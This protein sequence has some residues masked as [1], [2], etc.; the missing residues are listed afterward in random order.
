MADL[1]SPEMAQFLTDARK[2]INENQAILTLIILPI[3]GGIGK[4]LYDRQR[5]RPTVYLELADVTPIEGNEDVTFCLKAINTGGDPATK[6]RYTWTQRS[7]LT[8]TPVPAGFL[9]QKDNPRCFSFSMKADDVIGAG[10]VGWHQHPLGWIELTYCAGWGL[11]RQAKTA[12][13]LG[14]SP[15]MPVRLGKVPSPP[16]RDYIIP[17][18]NWH[19][20]RLRDK[21]IQN[22]ARYL[23]HSRE[24]L[25]ARGI[26]VQLLF[27]DESFRRLLGELQRRG[28]QWSY[29]PGGRGYEVYAKKEGPFYSTIRLSAQTPVDA[30]TLVVTSAVEDDEQYGLNYGSGP[31]EGN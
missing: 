6:V 17:L 3:L 24:F 21:D 16:W 31:A 1:I 26:E 12:I 14:E 5:N 10:L 9:L 23:Q 11:W 7:S 30:A 4:L 18:K 28:W 2:F 8:M 15:D 27:P 13:Y 29:G 19:E 20:K 22:F 25:A